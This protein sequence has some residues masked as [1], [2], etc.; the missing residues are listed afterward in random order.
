MSFNIL[1]NS[2][3]ATNS[4]FNIDFAFFPV[5]R[6][7][8]KLTFSA[9]TD[10]VAIDNRSE[11]STFVLLDINFRQSNYKPSSLNAT[12]STSVIGRLDLNI[13]PSD[14]VDYLCNVSTNA[15]ICIDN[16]PTDNFIE[17]K[18]V[19]TSNNIIS[20]NI[21]PGYYIQLNFEAV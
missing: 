6:G 5:H 13:M 1:L 10:P 16:K 21:V 3:E 8:Y 18:F 2:D 17:V 4:I 20:G 15:P 9:R 19:D 7:K 12:K 14:D 11:A